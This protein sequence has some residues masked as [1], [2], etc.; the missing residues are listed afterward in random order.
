MRTIE[1]IG[2]KVFDYAD[3][4]FGYEAEFTI[5]VTRA[6]KDYTIQSPELPPSD[7]P[8]KAVAL[9]KLISSLSYRA[10]KGKWQDG[11]EYELWSCVKGGP[12]TIGNTIVSHSDI[13]R[14]KEAAIASG[15]WITR[16]KLGEPVLLAPFA[17]WEIEYNKHS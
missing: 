6:G 15:G 4:N 7:L 12:K 5:I 17:S 2:R 1:D 11:I 9:F 10:Y 8:D 16:L 14:L 13:N 3:K